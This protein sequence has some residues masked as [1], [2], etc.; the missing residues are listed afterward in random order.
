MTAKQIQYYMAIFKHCNITK[1][2]E[3]LIV[4][5]PVISRALSDMERE[6][7]VR[8]FDRKSDGIVPT[9]GGVILHNMLDSIIKSYTITVERLRNLSAFDE[10]RGLRIGL[11]DAGSWWLYPIIYHKF[12]EIYPEVVVNVSGII[13]EDAAD[14]LLNASIDA[15]I[16]PIFE[17]SSPLLDSHYLY[18]TQWVLC[19]PKDL[20]A[21]VPHL[22]DSE[23]VELSIIKDLPIA[24]LETLAPP[25]Y[26]YK[27][28]VLSTKNADML[29]ITVLSGFAHAVLPLELCANWEGVNRRSLVPPI[30][31]EMFLL[32]NNSLPHSSA[33]TK[34][35]NFVKSLDFMSINESL[36]APES[37]NGNEFNH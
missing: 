6:L 31:P 20:N 24:I 21:T 3:E 35:I 22:P 19:S 7:C 9:E 26:E 29:R 8:L 28:V 12:H 23:S 1:A 5:R 37:S 30:A 17:D 16:A 27:N 14:L 13:A 2:A 11:M 25:F 15:A 32:W 34:F 36:G 10:S 18:T 4:T 33:F